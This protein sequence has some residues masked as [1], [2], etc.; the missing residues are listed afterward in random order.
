M[1]ITDS[2]V[3]GNNLFPVHP[4][5]N[6]QRDQDKDLFSALAKNHV[7]QIGAYEKNMYVYI[8]YKTLYASDSLPC[9]NK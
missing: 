2:Q 4:Q 1:F 8:S 3:P 7:K 9:Q 5:L 6:P